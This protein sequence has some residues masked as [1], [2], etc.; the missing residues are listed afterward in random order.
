MFIKHSNTEKSQVQGQYL[1]PQPGT[2]VLPPFVTHF[3]TPLSSSTGTVKRCHTGRKEEP[4]VY[5]SKLSTPVTH[6]GSTSHPKEKSKLVKTAQSFTFL[7]LKL[8]S[9]SGYCFK[10]WVNTQ[11]ISTQN[12]SPVLQHFHAPEAATPGNCSAPRSELLANTGKGQAAKPTTNAKSG[13]NQ[14]LESEGFTL[15]CWGLSHLL[16]LL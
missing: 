6:G 4:W 15:P 10:N 5:D 1:G 9:K 3:N 11:I 8:V 13:I 14:Q 7:C 12:F 2:E 16:L